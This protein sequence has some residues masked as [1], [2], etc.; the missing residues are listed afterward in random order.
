MIIVKKREHYLRMLEDNED[1]G[2]GVSL[3]AYM[4][5]SQPNI[6]LALA[7][8]VL[9]EWRSVVRKLK[10]QYGEVLTAKQVLAEMHIDPK[11]C[12]HIDTVG[13][14]DWVRGDQCWDVD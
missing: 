2:I 4:V 9:D 11:R 7:E 10:A 13:L 12:D 14:K 6:R 1:A 8:S 5:V 3:A